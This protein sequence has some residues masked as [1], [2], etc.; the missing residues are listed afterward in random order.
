V[1]LSCAGGCRLDC[2]AILHSE[3]RTGRWA[4][5]TKKAAFEKEAKGPRWFVVREDAPTETAQGCCVLCAM[6]CI[7]I[8]PG[9]CTLHPAHCPFI[10]YIQSSLDIR[11][12]AAPA[13]PNWSWLELHT[14]TSAVSS[15]QCLL[16]IASC[17]KSGP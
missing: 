13:P 6:C 17:K 9:F 14:T 15:D 7:S 4:V 12:S 2:G 8:K 3:L 5:T 11:F 10:H 16:A 1:P